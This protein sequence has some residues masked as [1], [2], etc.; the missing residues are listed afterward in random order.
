MR[1]AANVVL[2]MALM[3]YDQEQLYV[4]TKDEEKKIK[5]I[6]CIESQ[7]QEQQQRS[8]HRE[9][10][11]WMTFQQTTCD[12][13]RTEMTYEHKI[14]LHCDEMKMRRLQH[15]YM[16]YFTSFQSDDRPQTYDYQNK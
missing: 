4:K 11:L 9:N 15:I 3:K 16:C 1:S 12:E 8:K 7:G 5:L 13:T 6:V 2:A 10:V 14:K